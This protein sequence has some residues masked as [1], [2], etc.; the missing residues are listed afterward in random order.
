METERR[1]LKIENE[2]YRAQKVKHKT[3]NEDWR[4]KGVECT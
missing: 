4:I 2:E 3:W 1:L